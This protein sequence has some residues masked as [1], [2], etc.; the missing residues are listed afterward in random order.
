ML[1]KCYARVGMLDLVLIIIFIIGLPWKFM[2]RTH[3]K[4]YYVVLS[5]F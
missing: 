2:N 1:T 3:N 4:T 5:Q